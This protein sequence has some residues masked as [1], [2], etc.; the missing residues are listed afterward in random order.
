MI[1]DD[2]F[3]DENT[4]ENITAL[5]P[6]EQKLWHNVIKQFRIDC[7]VGFEGLSIIRFYEWL[8]R[9][10]GRM[11]CNLAGVEA[12]YLLRKAKEL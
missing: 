2:N 10:D 3:F 9:A 5:L 1:D 7:I 12:D 6:C 8:E 4:F 11:V